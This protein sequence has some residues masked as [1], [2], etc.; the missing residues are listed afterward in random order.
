M[1]SKVLVVISTA[2]KDKALTGLLYATNALKK[3]W[4][5]DVKVFF[6][7]P[8]EKL[9]IED[10][11]IQEKVKALLEYQK[12]LACKFIA[13]NEGISNSLETLG[14]ELDYVGST[15]SEHIKQGYVPM[16]F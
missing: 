10:K 8:F 2:E 14:Y 1:S 11:D 16:V 3:Q 5:D 4:L 7:G 12:P 9:V 6:F 15:I 13:D